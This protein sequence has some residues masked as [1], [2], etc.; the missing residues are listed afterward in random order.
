MGFPVHEPLL[1][2]RW[3]FPEHAPLL[4]IR[5]GEIQDS[6]MAGV[7]D[8]TFGALRT[9]HYESLH[10]ACVSATVRE[11]ACRIGGAV[12]YRAQAH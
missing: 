8:L 7:P 3:L 5:Q 10:V 4:S 6:A 12:F 2:S 1:T 11:C 9:G